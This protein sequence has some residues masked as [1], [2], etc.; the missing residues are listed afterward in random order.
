MIFNC[1]EVPEAYQFP[2]PY[3]VHISKCLRRIAVP[4]LDCEP[5]ISLRSQNVNKLIIN[6]YKQIINFHVA[7][8][9]FLPIISVFCN[10]EDI[11]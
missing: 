6:K 8:N 5:S 3:I 9:V 1:S 11:A 2:L 10:A 4:F 7:E